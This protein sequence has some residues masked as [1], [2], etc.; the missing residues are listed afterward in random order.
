MKYSNDVLAR[1]WKK[2]NKDAPGGCWLWTASCVAD[3]YGQFNKGSKQ[4]VRAHRFA[5]EA[6]V[7]PIPDGLT[8]DHLCRVR[9]CVNPAHLEPVSMRVNIM[10][11][12]SSGAVN[13][14]KTHCIH[15]HEFTPENTQTSQSRGWRRCLTCFR[16]RDREAKKAARRRRWELED[17]TPD[18]K[19]HLRFRVR[20]EAA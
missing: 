1:F 15:G 16:V 12:Q 17:T 13:A 7:G 9:G 19:G 8:L 4:M 18:L 3:G 5:Y 20:K 14:R 2:V 11:G 10:R 6:C